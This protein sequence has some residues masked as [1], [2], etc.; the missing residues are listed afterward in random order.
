MES[1]MLIKVG[2]PGSVNLSYSNI[3]IFSVPL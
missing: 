2:F 3:Q 1:A